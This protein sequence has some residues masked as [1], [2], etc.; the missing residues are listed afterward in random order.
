M[1]D[2]YSQER[3]QDQNYGYEIP[4]DYGIRTGLR[5]DQFSRSVT[6]PVQKYLFF[7]VRTGP[8][9]FY[10]G[11]LFRTVVPI[12]DTIIWFGPMIRE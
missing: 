7:K 4:T 6:G 1:N 2:R 12:S 9:F 5:T 8:T 11:T 3:F 10:V